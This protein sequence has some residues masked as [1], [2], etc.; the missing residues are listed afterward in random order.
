MGHF[1]SW[2]AELHP[3]TRYDMQV[4]IRAGFRG[5]ELRQALGLGPEWKALV[6]TTLIGGYRLLL[7]RSDA[8]AG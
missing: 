7:S 1:F 3:I 4:S 2:L 5:D 6:R 8:Q